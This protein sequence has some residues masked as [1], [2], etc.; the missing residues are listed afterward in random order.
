MKKINFLFATAIFL[1]LA[2]GNINAQNKTVVTDSW[3]WEGEL[4]CTDD[5]VYGVESM[6][7]TYWQS[8]MQVRY[9]G[10]YEGVSGKHYTWSMVVNDNWKSLVEG[11][12]ANRT[13]V[14]TSVIE[15]EGIPIAIY[16]VRYH[17]T[18]NANGEIVIERYFDS[19]DDW[20]CL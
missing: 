4:M 19:G 11:Q 2:V 3:D 12:A 18:I 15:C 7:V 6:V 10:E 14:S 9:K 1:F 13:Y 16:K 17:I 8:K 20:I 5:Y